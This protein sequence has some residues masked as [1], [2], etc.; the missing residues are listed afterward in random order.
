MM[1]TSQHSEELLSVW[2]VDVILLK[3][4]RWTSCH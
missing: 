4:K 2:K 3:V 1:V